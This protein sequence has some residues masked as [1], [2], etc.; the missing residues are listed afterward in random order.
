MTSQR[1]LPSPVRSAPGPANLTFPPG[2]PAPEP[3]DGFW[4]QVKCRALGP[5]LVT[6]QLSSQRLS[7][8]LAL[9]VL[10]CDGLSSAAYGT[11]EIL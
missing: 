5:P 3:A 2:S 10:S 1:L 11:E 7:R 4:Y 6:E 8:P 9:G